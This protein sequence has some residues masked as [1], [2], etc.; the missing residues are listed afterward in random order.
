MHS[1]STRTATWSSWA[2]KATPR[3]ATM[4]LRTVSSCNR[5]CQIMG[6]ILQHGS[7]RTSNSKKLITVAIAHL[8]Y[9]PSPLVWS[10]YISAAGRQTHC[11]STS[12]AACNC[13][14][15]CRLHER[16]WSVRR[17]PLTLCR[18]LP[19]PLVGVATDRHCTVPVADIRICSQTSHH[20]HTGWLC[21]RL[22]AFTCLRG[23]SG[24]TTSNCAQPV[25]CD[26]AAIGGVRTDVQR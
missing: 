10:R 1:T 13:C 20:A 24:A 14:S 16:W 11:C 19:A 5:L 25:P 9:S 6:S 17:G 23:C 12:R 18:L 15:R 3:C 21:V 2:S 7:H 26:D 8:H 4:R 22:P